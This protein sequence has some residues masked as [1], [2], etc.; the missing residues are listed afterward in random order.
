MTASKM[1]S[2]TG[3]K[4]N[5]RIPSSRVVQAPVV[6]SRRSVK[7]SADFIGSTPNLIMVASTGLCLAA[8]RF[9]LAPTVNKF[10]TSGLNLVDKPLGLKTGD[11]A[12]FTAVD[13]LALGSFGHMIGIGIVLGLKATGGL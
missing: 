13:V 2:F 12:G 10:A 11:P 6:R 7:V 1:S 3:L 5:T 8:G 4:A 9:G